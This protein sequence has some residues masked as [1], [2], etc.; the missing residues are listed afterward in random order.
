MLGLKNINIARGLFFTRKTA[1][2]TRDLLFA[3]K[4]ANITRF[5]LLYQGRTGSTFIIDS[6]G[7]HPNVI[8]RGEFLSGKDAKA[9]ESTIR[10]FYSKAPK[11]AQALGFKTKLRDIA[12]KKKFLA[13]M[14]EFD[15]KM[16]FMYRSNLV[17]LA[18][19]KLNAHRIFK[20]YG[21]WNRLK[22]QEPLPQFAPT[23][24]EFDE[25]LQ[26]RKTKEE[27]L[28]EFMKEVKRDM[29]VRDHQDLIDDPEKLFNE[30]FDYIGVEPAPLSS[31][32]RKNESDNMR[33]D[34]LNYDE[35][36]AHYSDTPYAKM[37]D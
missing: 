15:V 17:K 27:E 14:D 18:L 4:V 28:Q 26:F 12:D 36:K 29:I 31:V 10:N 32:V 34:L 9:Q 19:S 3:R 24:E 37:F 35:I 8:T 25:A 2:I 7:S 22:G 5:V 16:I 33:D 30:Y 20:K 13:L 23:I 6:M 11:S 1:N 21:T